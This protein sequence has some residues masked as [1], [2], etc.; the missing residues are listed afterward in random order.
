M[1]IIFLTSIKSIISTVKTKKNHQIC[2]FLTEKQIHIHGNDMVLLGLILTSKCCSDHCDG[3][4]CSLL[5]KIK[6]FSKTYLAIPASY[7]PSTRV[8]SLAGH[9]VLQ[10][11]AIS[12]HE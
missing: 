7:I 6:H 3:G 11:L 2:R 12:F 1:N 9:L 4:K 10:I 5:S 8:F